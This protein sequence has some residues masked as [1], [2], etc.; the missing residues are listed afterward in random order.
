MPQNTIDPHIQVATSAF[1]EKLALHFDVNQTFLFGSMARQSGHAESDADVAVVLNGSTGKF[2]DTKFAM[3]DLAYEVL[4]D[5]GI[6][7]Q[8]LP[9]WLN[10]WEN[11]TSF[12]NPSLLYNIQ[13]EGL[14]V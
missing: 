10:E 6:R 9:I 11:P 2:I 13:R 8:P 7:I 12:P 4:L 5:T 1:K 3:D 14:V